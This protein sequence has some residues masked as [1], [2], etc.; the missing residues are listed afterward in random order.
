MLLPKHEDC[1]LEDDSLPDMNAR[2][3]FPKREDWLV[4]A[5]QLKVRN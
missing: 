1:Y 3:A 2:A 5:G 4:V